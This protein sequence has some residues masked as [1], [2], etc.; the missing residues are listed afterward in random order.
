MRNAGPAIGRDQN[1]IY[2]SRG[3]DIIILVILIPLYNSPAKIKAIPPTISY[4]YFQD[5]I[6]TINKTSAGI[7]CINNPKIVP[8]NP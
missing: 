8:Q 3:F 1:S 2:H 4:S 5:I 7:L 6:R